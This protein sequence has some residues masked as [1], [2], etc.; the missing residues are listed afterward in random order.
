MNRIKQL[1][2]EMGLTLRDLDKAIGIPFTSIS[3]MEKETYSIN[4]YYLNVLADFFKVSADYLL[5]RSDV[6]EPSI[7]QK[8]DEKVVLEQNEVLYALYGEVK[9][10]SEEQIKQI[11]DFAMYLKERSEKK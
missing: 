3:N 10:L 9:E 4:S 6:R 1:R 2:K 5:G 8:Q 11:M 7:V